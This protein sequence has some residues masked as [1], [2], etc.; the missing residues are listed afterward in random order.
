MEKNDFLYTQLLRRD[1]LRGMSLKCISLIFFSILSLSLF[2]DE[3]EC[4]DTFISLMEN[5]ENPTMIAGG[6]SDSSSMGPKFPPNTQPTLYNNTQEGHSL[7]DTYMMAEKN[8]ATAECPQFGEGYTVNFQDI[9]ILQLIQFISK[10]SNTNFIFDSN[11]LQFNVTIV[12]EEASS[13][14]DLMTALIQ[15]LKTRGFSITE[16]GNNILIFRSQALSKVSK[17]ITELNLEESCNTAIVTRVF[18][19][20]HV[21]PTR[22]AQIIIPLLSP[23]AV[24]EVSEETKHLIVT[25]MTGNV[26]KIADLLNALDIPSQVYEYAEYQTN[27]AHP[28]ALIAHAKAILSPIAGDTAIQMLAQPSTQKIFIAS[29]PALIAKAIEVLSNLD[30]IDIDDFAQLDLP[31]DSMDKN[32]FFMY[33]LKYQSGDQIAIALQNIGTDLQYSGVGN[34]DFINTL[35]SVKWID[36]NNSM[37]ITGSQEAIDKVVNLLKELD[38]AP[39]Q[40]FVEVLIIDTSLSNSLDFGVQWIALGDE[41]NKLAYASGLLSNSPPNPNL[42]GGTATNPGA[43]YIAS[44]PAANPPSTPNPGRDVALPVP[45]QLAGEAALQNQTAAFGLGVIGNIVRHK[46][47]SF[48]T[49][50]A[51]VSALDV[52]ADTRIVLNPRIMVEDNQPADFFVGENIPYQTT[53]TVIQQTGSVT[54]NIQYED[55]GVQLRVTPTISPRNVVTLEIEQAIAEVVNTGDGGVLPTT[56]KTLATTRVHVP[57]G[58]FLV[59]SGSIRDESDF[60]RSGI[61]CLGTLPLIGPTFSR[62]I[63]IR[64]KRNLILFVRPKVVTNIQ[65]GLDLTNQEGYDYNWESHPC[66]ITECGTEKAPECE[67]FPPPAC[68][69]N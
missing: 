53:S 33:K 21:N 40:V 63:E 47:Q 5:F 42:Q 32:N 20:M 67:T 44:N 69:T 61:P 11:D 36:V 4:S 56:R 48:L 65:E 45:T 49:L 39:K 34:I 31:S 14:E 66:S 64:R 6:P 54:Q 1:I 38:T 13:V 26:D 27:S 68:P 10:I 17:I 8:F 37:V 52:E 22:M 7:F 30:S 23:E 62:T 50:G 51:L 9:S 55:V 58:T 24:V 25:D 57:D 2:A 12:S 29:T 28:E 16:S 46:G 18:R 41:Q 19:L 35:T 60:I 3:S 43:R 15:I 59:M